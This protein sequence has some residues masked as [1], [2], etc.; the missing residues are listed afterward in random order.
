MLTLCFNVSYEN[1]HVRILKQWPDL[2]LLLNKTKQNV[3]II[4]I[5]YINNINIL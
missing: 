2:H 4:N 3:C 5:Q 1:K